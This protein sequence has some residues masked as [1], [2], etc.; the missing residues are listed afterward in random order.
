L[1][2]DPQVIAEAQ[3]LFHAYFEDSAAL[4]ADLRGVVF[5]AQARRGDAAHLKQLRERYEASN[6]IEEKLDC[7]TAL[8]LFKSLELKR[9]VIAWGL[10]T[11]RSQDIQYVFSSVAADAP[12]AEFAWTYVQEHWAALNEQYR[13][14]IVG[15]IVMSV[16]SRFQTEAHAHEVE[17]FLATRKHSSY[18]R[19]LDA[20]LERIRV[21]SACYQR[22]R[23]ELAK[24]LQSI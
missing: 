5:N 22:N 10:K 16:V 15:R 6:F 23:D 11:V 24:W 18:T 7:L 17:T 9:D 3:R 14:L 19:L 20:A 8:G 1:G 21:K 12:G 2:E 13:P 4:S